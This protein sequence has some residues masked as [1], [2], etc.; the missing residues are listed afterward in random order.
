MR[1]QVEEAAEGKG[2]GRGIFAA[3]VVMD[4]RHRDAEV[5]VAKHALPAML[6]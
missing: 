5:M 1:T 4:W 3:P 6:A 2:E